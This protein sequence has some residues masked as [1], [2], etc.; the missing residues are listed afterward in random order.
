MMRN[1]QEA[2]SI[3]R[4]GALAVIPLA[5]GA[6]ATSIAFL[7]LRGSLPGKVATHFTLS[8]TADGFSSP[9]TALGQYMLVFGIEAVGALAVVFSVKPTRTS[10]RA[11]TVFSSALAAG[12]AYLLI[13]AMEA[14]ADSN[15]P[16]VQLPIYQLVVALAV[17]VAIGAGAWYVARRR[18][19]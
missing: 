9:A 7:L 18:H 8:G 1:V 13:A 14:N 16:K 17:S 6:I 12:T 4:R 19:A 2:A 3:T 10:A 15:G 11:I 5:L